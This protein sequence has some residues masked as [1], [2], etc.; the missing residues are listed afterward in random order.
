MFL[1]YGLKNSL[2]D[3]NPVVRVTCSES[4]LETD[5]GDL[6]HQLGGGIF[7]SKIRQAKTRY[8]SMKNKNELSNSIFSKK[9]YKIICLIIGIIISLTLFLLNRP[10]NI[11]LSSAPSLLNSSPV[12]IYDSLREDSLRIQS[13]TGQ[14]AKTVSQAINIASQGLGNYQRGKTLVATTARFALTTNKDLITLI[15]KF[16]PVFDNW[17][18]QTDEIENTIINIFGLAAQGKLSVEDLS[19]TLAKSGIAFRNL[20]TISEAGAFLE[21][22]SN[23]TTKD[24]AIETFTHMSQAVINKDDPINSIPKI[25]EKGGIAI[26]IQKEGLVNSFQYIANYLSN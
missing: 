2:Q 9:N 15:N 14:N 5:T 1:G 8:K 3:K 4:Y 6:G 12:N 11:I 16:I 13:Q 20:T 17:N 24:T 22:L 26:V 23:K 25:K 7:V 10:D 18:I 21:A 19:D